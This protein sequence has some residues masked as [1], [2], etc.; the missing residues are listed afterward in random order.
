M[1]EKIRAFYVLHIF[2][3]F[4]GRECPILVI[5][6]QPEAE[7]LSLQI[8]EV[9]FHFHALLRPLLG[10]VCFGLWHFMVEAVLKRQCAFDVYIYSEA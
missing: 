1:F 9:F 2:L 4:G 10:F 3:G 5:P 7:C 6:L 8:F